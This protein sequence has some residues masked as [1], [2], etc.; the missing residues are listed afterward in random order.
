MTTKK[1]LEIAERIISTGLVSKVFHSV[2]LLRDEN[3]KVLYPVYQLG[4]D[5]VYSGIDDAKGLF[6]YIRHNGDMAGVPFKIDSCGRNYTMTAPMRVVFFN[7]N[8][9]RDHE[10]LVRQLGSF[11]FLSGLTLTRIVTDKFRLVK[12]ESAIFREKFDG[13]TF[14]VAFDINA[15][16]ILLPGDCETNA[17]PVHPNPVLTCPAAVPKLTESATS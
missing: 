17:C 7:D 9:T 10:E 12:E 1:Q 13:T 14:Y 3:S 6:A 16:F 15:T 11:T 8:E 2:T 4:S 5:F